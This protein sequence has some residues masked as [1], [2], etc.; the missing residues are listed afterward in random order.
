MLLFLDSV[1]CLGFCAARA[2]WAWLWGLLEDPYIKK[3]STIFKGYLD[4]FERQWVG[5][6][7]TAQRGKSRATAP[8]N[9]QGA[10]LK[11]EIKTTSSLEVWHKH[12]KANFVSNPN[13]NNFFQK[14]QGEQSQ[15]VSNFCDLAKQVALNEKSK[16]HDYQ[17][18]VQKVVKKN[19]R[20]VC[21]STCLVV[22]KVGLM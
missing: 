18:D 15:S 22:L 16:K 10:C 4:Y 19:I 9:C 8:W 14:L 21:W 2:Y 3:H 12:M 13:Y 7:V 11:G 1:C 6:K 20:F 17:E 5:K